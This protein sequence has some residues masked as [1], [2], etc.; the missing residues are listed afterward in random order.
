MKSDPTAFLTNEM[1][2]IREAGR[3]WIH[4]VLEGPSDTVCKVEGKEVIM[5]CSNNY[6]GLS[7]HPKMKEAAV[8]AIK[9]HGVGSGSVRAI[10]GNMDLHEQWEHRLAK[11]K[12]QEAAFITSAGFAAN[13]GVI[14]QLAPTTDDIILSDRLNHGSI[15]DGVRTTKAKRAVYEHCD[16]ASLE[17]ELT[18]LAK[19]NPRRILVITDGVFSMDGDHAPLDEIYKTCETHSNTIIYVD[20]AHGDGV[21]GRNYSGKGLVDH[22][23]L[24]GKVHIE[25][26]TFS[27]AFGTM[28]GSIVGS[29]ELITWCRNKTRSY[30]LSASHPPATAAASIKA[31]DLIEHEEPD[32]VKRLWDNIDYFKKEIIDMGYN[33]EITSASTTAI[34]PIIFGDPLKAKEASNLLYSEYSIFALPIVFPMVPRGL[35][36][37]RVQANAALTKEQLNEGLRA[38]EEVGKNLKVF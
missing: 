27:K 17:E 1:Q 38:F 4:R 24:Q 9:T 5:L 14:Q 33:H 13:Q 29:Q 20:D 25:M 26:G 8:E 12:E 34:I 16:M 11:F 23:G 2:E 31:L 22:Y 3:E 18:K 7:N 32:L 6:L 28:G 10:A 30:L 15:I 19:G 36:R 21:L 35:D 37:I